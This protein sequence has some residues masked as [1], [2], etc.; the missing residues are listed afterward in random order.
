MILCHTI[1]V[2]HTTAPMH[3]LQ[4][5]C[6]QVRVS[7][8][9][10]MLTLWWCDLLWGMA[11]ISTWARG[12]LLCMAKLSPGPSFCW[13][14]VIQGHTSQQL[15]I[16]STNC[17]V[18][19][20]TFIFHEITSDHPIMKPNKTCGHDYVSSKVIRTMIY[21]HPRMGQVA[22]RSVRNIQGVFGVTHQ[23]TQKSEEWRKIADRSA[24][25]WAFSVMTFV[26][27]QYMR[28]C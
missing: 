20:H 2:T 9:G 18:D 3:P 27:L 26:L 4:M 6:I 8:M 1:P 24:M 19:Q 11:W 21:N 22:Y 10:Q 16:F 5:W 14:P 13:P 23:T 7:T 25:T 28:H 15:H 17:T 12:P